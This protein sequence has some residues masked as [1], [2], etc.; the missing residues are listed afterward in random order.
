MLIIFIYYVGNDIEIKRHFWFEENEF[1]VVEAE[2]NLTK[3]DYVVSME[4]VGKLDND[5]KGLYR[6]T[7]KDQNGT[8]M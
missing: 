2:Q 8:E 5:L 1:Y 7:Y 6:S 4:F 3:G